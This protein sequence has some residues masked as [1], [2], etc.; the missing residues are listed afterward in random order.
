LW[1]GY[2]SFSL[3]R[4]C[5]GFQEITLIGFVGML[6][7][8]FWKAVCYGLLRVVQLPELICSRS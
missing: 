7:L 4:I 1:A 8:V 6:R 2:I 3:R 5:L